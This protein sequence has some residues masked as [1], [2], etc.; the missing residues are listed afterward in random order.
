VSKRLKIFFLTT[1][2]FAGVAVL[3][4]PLL[5][6]SV[7]T[8]MEVPHSFLKNPIR[9]G[10]AEQTVYMTPAPQEMI[11]KEIVA[12]AIRSGQIDNNPAAT[13][14]RLNE[15]AK[16]LKPHEIRALG[17]VVKTPSSDGDLRAVA[18]DLLA[19]NKSEENQKTLEEIIYSKWPENQ[20]P[21]LDDFER[22]LRA[23]AVEGV[24]SKTSLANACSKLEDKFLMDRACR[25][26]NGEKSLAEQD[27]EALGK[28]LKR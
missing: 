27:Q 9:R 19:R 4:W 11:S 16:N 17:K 18:V 26:Y 5:P 6:I 3:L 21:R 28:I 8:E 22:A 12:E 2:I 14:H 23:R 15:L 25:A 10:P 7:S 13:E 24:G 20:D 1:G